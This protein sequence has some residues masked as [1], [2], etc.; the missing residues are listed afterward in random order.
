MKEG[1][2]GFQTKDLPGPCLGKVHITKEGRLLLDGKDLE[3]H[4]MLSF[5]AIGINDRG[6]FDGRSWDYE[7]KFTDG[8]CVNIQR[9]EDA[10]E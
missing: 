7:A 6:R 1:T 8:V 5:M 10:D 3:Y 4:G 2:F 9:I